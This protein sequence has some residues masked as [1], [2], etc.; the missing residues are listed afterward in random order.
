LE[1]AMKL[2]KSF[3]GARV[4][5]ISM[6]PE[7]ARKVLKEAVAMGA[8][9]GILLT[10]KAFAG[11]DTIAT[12]RALAAAIKKAGPFD[13]ILCGERATDGE[14]G[15]TGAMV[16]AML[17]VPVHT[18]VNRIVLRDG[19]A[20]IVRMVEGG[21]ERVEVP[22]PALFS[23]VKGINQPGFPTLEGKIRARQAEIVVWGP[24]DLGLDRDELGLK[25]SPTRVVKVFSPKLARDTIMIRHDDSGRAVREL[26]SFL[27]ARKAI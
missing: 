1:E 5:A 6:G 24:E 4:T 11:S 7:S 17:D 27:S 8:D 15:Q 21:F 2:K 22:L 25:G 3:E 16:A 14:T 23:V 9:A 10:G 13:L 12:A 20:E 19:W 18:Y 26:L